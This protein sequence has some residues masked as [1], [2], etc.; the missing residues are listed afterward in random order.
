V[1][2][3]LPVLWNSVISLIFSALLFGGTF[4]GITTLST[5]L[6]RQIQTG[7]ST[8]LFGFMTVMY[9]GGQMIGPAI[10]GE[11]STYTNNYNAAL[12]GAACA[13]FIGACCLVSGVKYERIRGDY[14]VS[15]KA[16][17]RD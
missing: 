9:A 3:I 17:S 8:R 5:T 13:V 4:M 6:A 11:I 1:G 16:M 10:A 12:I 2:I 7:S 14:P 15:V